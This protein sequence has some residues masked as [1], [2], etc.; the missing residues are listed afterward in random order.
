MNEGEP[1]SLPHFTVEKVQEEKDCDA[2][3]A[4]NERGSMAC[5]VTN[6]SSNEVR[7]TVL[8]IENAKKLDEENH[9]E[10]QL[11]VDRS[12]ESPEASSRIGLVKSESW[13]PV[14]NAENSSQEAEKLDVVVP[15]DVEKETF[16]EGHYGEVASSNTAVLLPSTFKPES[17]GVSNIPLS[18]SF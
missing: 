18:D 10:I 6:E 9:P 8:Q 2:Q 12:F 1:G 17:Q 13:E 4:S 15:H 11:Y 7:Q 3:E 16:E 14:K 5:E